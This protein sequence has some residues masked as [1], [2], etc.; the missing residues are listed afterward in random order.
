MLLILGDVFITAKE[1]A[2]VLRREGYVDDL[3]EHQWSVNDAAGLAAMNRQNELSPVAGLLDRDA[4]LDAIRGREAAISGIFTHFFPVSR[5]LISL[6][7]KLR[8][9][10]TLR[11]G[12]QNIDTAAAS[13]RGVVVVNNPGRNTEA[14][15]QFSVGLMLATCR[16]IAQGH[17]SLIHGEWPGLAFR[18]RQRSLSDSTIGIV[19]F[20]QIG[21]RVASL[22]R[23]FGAT[24]LAY[25]PYEAADGEGVRQVECLDQ[26]LEESDIVTVHARAVPGAPP[27]LGLPQLE[28]IGP[29]GILINTARAELVDEDALVQV[30]RDRRLGAAGLDVFSVEPLPAGHPLRS[31]PNVTLTPHL[32]GRVRGVNAAAIRLLAGRV[33]EATGSAA[34]SGQ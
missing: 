17:A 3:L 12:L 25:D 1:I 2:D 11:S 14:V 33:R 28:R 15:A 13:D 20:G 6:L 23:P 30:L 10:A 5:E 22:L 8:Y 34:R 9:V 4:L 31:V 29:E 7:P 32:A 24:M 21:R 26:L 16:G 18:D 19:G 27:I